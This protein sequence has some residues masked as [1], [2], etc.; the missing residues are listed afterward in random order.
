MGRTRRNLPCRVSCRAAPDPAFRGVPHI[1]ASLE[2]YRLGIVSGGLDKLEGH[3]AWSRHEQP[4]EACCKL[5]AGTTAR[6]P[7]TT[8]LLIYP[9]YQQ[10][11][12]PNCR[13]KPSQAMLC[14]FVAGEQVE[15]SPEYQ[16]DRL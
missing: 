15:R 2:C 8:S 10:S 3:Q 14:A 6:V 1:R 4:L 12:Y 7:P 16:S 9:T 13:H 5:L 11:T